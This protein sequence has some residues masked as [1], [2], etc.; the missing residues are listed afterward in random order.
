MQRVRNAVVAG[1][2]ITAAVLPTVLTSGDDET[3]RLGQNWWATNGARSGTANFQPDSDLFT[4]CDERPDGHD[5][6]GTVL[7]GQQVVYSIVADGGSGDCER[8]HQGDGGKFNLHEA[9]IYHFK[10]CLTLVDNC[11]IRKLPA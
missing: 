3:D 2:V 1:V 11:R 8:R 6:V 10:V 7:D 9:R 5:V 4:V